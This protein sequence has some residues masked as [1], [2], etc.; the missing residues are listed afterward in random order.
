VLRKALLTIGCV[1]IAAGLVASLAAGPAM[2]P[3]VVFPAL[4][5]IGLL[6][7]RFLYKP[8]LEAPPGAGWQRTQERFRDPKSDRVVVVF[9]NP[10]TGERTYVAEASVID[11]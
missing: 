6:C 2:L 11:G 7:E 1:L 8:I 5:V 10:R 4:L 3:L 9:Y